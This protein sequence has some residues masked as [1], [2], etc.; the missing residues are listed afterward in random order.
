MLPRNATLCVTWIRSVT[1]R[2]YCPVRR[3]PAAS[4]LFTA[5]GSRD[6]RRRLGDDQGA[7]QILDPGALQGPILRRAAAGPDASGSLCLFSN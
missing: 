6:A 2:S 3:V 1:L 5:E 4:V 7:T